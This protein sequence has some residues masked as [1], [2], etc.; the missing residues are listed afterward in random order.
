M[1]EHPD[2]YTEPPRVAFSVDVRVSGLPGKHRAG[3]ST[4]EGIRD[5][6]VVHVD[7][8]QRGDLDVAD[9]N[10]RVRHAREPTTGVPSGRLGFE[11]DAPREGR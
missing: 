10:G 4:R 1:T 5:R 8:E 9:G 3:G 11:G 6:F 7:V 2:A